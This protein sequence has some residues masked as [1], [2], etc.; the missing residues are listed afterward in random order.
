MSGPEQQSGSRTRRAVVAAMPGVGLLLHY[1]R[2]WMR[3]DLLAALSLWAVLVPQALA[4][5]QLAGLAPVAGLYCA[6]AAVTA[7]ALLGTSRY[8]NVGPESSVAVLIAAALTPLA[9]GDPD[10]YAAL[11]AALALLVGALLLLGWVVRAG[12]VTRLLSAPVLTGY[13]AGSAVVIMISQLPRV[14]GIRRDEQYPTVLGG[15]LRNLDQINPRAVVLAAATAL[16]GILAAAVS[17]RLPAPLLALVVATLMVVLFDWT[18]AVDVVG[19]VDSG[20]PVPALPDV[21]LRDVITL[22]PDAASIAVLVFAGSV[23]AARSLAVRDREDL[24]A[25]REFV[26]LG[27]ANIAAGFFQSFPA[28]GS[29]SRSF[30]V[31]D[32]GGRSQAVGL[33]SGVLV[34]VT[35]LVLTPLFADVPDAALGAVVIAAAIRLVDVGELRRLWRIRRSDF[36]LAV[37]TLIG[38]LVLGVLGGIVVGVTVSL[39]EVL[40]RAVLPHT[41]VLGRVAGTLSWR[42]VDNYHDSETVPGVVVYRF[43]A[44]LFFANA[45]VFRDQVRRLVADA[46]HP[47]RSVVVNAEAVYDIDTTGLATLDRLLDDLSDAGAALVLA[48]VRTSVRDLMRR[49]GLEERIGEQNFHLTV[50]DAVGAQAAPTGGPDSGPLRAGD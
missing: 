11:A 17:R 23:L 48:R 32:G 33:G 42:D 45:D 15:L 9:A 39:L 43:D 14:T 8:L 34:L 31:A 44:A 2:R 26:G 4:Y 50:A 36:V 3:P 19:S 21:S 18:D 41:A 16:V 37:V 6:L 25:N 13:L 28:N 24:D 22:L 1:D 29:D 47:L 10:R 7:Y 46:E 35:L 40:R 12:V 38:V 27:A 5:G 49:T 30:V 20:L